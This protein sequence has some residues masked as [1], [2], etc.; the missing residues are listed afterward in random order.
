MIMMF[1]RFYV[2]KHHTPSHIFEHYRLTYEG[3]DFFLKSVLP[4][5]KLVNI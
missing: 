4:M 5:E 3:A 2:F 1:K